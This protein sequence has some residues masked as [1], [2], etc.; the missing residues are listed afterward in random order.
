LGLLKSITKPVLKAIWIAA[1][2]C[3]ELDEIEQPGI[4][5]P[6]STT[7]NEKNVGFPHP[8]KAG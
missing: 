6:D 3:G 7:E 5:N 4:E 2:Q 1:E 8:C